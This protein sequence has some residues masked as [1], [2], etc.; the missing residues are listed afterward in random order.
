[1][2]RI[3]KNVDEMIAISM[4][5]NNDHDVAKYRAIKKYCEENNTTFETWFIDPTADAEEDDIKETIH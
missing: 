2:Q 4:K 3:K 1:M 5:N